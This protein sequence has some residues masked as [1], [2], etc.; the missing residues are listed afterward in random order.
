MPIN[1]KNSKGTTPIKPIDVTRE[2]SLENVVPVAGGY[3]KF[4]SNPSIASSMAQANSCIQTRLQLASPVS[5]V[6]L[7][8]DGLTN[9]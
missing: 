8:T 4:T 9:A 5:A 3:I 2:N 1:K 7:A 6:Y